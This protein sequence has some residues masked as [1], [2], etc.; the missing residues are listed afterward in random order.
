MI[1]LCK[2][3]KLI[4]DQISPSKLYYYLNIEDNKPDLYKSIIHICKSNAWN[5]QMTALNMRRAAP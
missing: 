1:A 3:E 4:R 2:L 5:A